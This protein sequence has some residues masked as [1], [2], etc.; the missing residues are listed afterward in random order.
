MDWSKMRSYIRCY[1]SVIIVISQGYR[2]LGKPYRSVDQSVCRFD[3]RNLT[4]DGVASPVHKFWNPKPL[5]SRGW[6]AWRVCNS[7]LY[8]LGI[9]CRLQFSSSN[10]SEVLVTSADSLVR[11][12]DGAKLVQKYKVAEGWKV[13]VES[14]SLQ[15]PRRWWAAPQLI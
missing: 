12:L 6:R 2:Y 4:S 10:P 11:I 14:F 3:C 1:E 13:L 8:N 15:Q 5:F 9:A 7:T